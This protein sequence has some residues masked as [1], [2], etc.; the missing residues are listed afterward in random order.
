MDWVQISSDS[1]L[2]FGKHSGSGFIGFEFFTKLRVPIYRV[3]GFI[4]FER[5]I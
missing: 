4:M 5:K 2:R 1:G 3:F